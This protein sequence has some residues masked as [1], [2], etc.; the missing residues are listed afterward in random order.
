MGSLLIHLRDPERLG[1]GE[2]HTTCG[3]DV[4]ASLHAPSGKCVR[5]DVSADNYE[6]FL[7]LSLATLLSLLLPVQEGSGELVPVSE[8]CSASFEIRFVS[9]PRNADD[10]LRRANDGSPTGVREC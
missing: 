1:V 2:C 3:I 4:L 9:V 8:D 10:D 6:A 7:N 5:V